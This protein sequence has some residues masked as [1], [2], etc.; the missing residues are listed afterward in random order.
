MSIININLKT[1]VN[2]K[3]EKYGVKIKN[4]EVISPLM[5]NLIRLINIITPISHLR[6]QRK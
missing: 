6:K 2:I 5:K 3:A 1:T 4:K